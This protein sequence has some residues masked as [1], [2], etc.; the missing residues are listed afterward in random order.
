MSCEEIFPFLKIVSIGSFIY[1]YLIFNLLIV[2]K[3]IGAKSKLLLKSLF[4]YIKKSII[5]LFI[6]SLSKVSELWYSFFKYKT[7]NT[8]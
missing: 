7:T 8:L 6:V 5:H 1:Y 3:S 2:N 4:F